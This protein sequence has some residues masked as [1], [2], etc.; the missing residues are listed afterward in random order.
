MIGKIITGKSFRNCLLYCLSDKH[1]NEAM[2]NR[3]EVLSYNQCYGNAKEL[4]KEFNDVRNLN[5]KVSKPVFHITLS[6]APGERLKNFELTEIAQQCAMDLDF[7]K[8]QFVAV[9][10]KDTLHQHLHIIAN[11]I[12]FDGRTVS[13]SNNY[14]KIVNFCRRVEAYYKLSTVLNPRRFLDKSMRNLPRS[15]QRKLKLKSDIADCL[16]KTKSFDEFT[17]EMKALGYSV[18]KGRG[19][20]FLDAQKVYTKGSDV[21]YS[22][23]K[24]QKVIDMPAEQKEAILNSVKSLRL[25]ENDP[26]KTI[27]DLSQKANELKTEEESI[28]L[29][30]IFSLKSE[31]IEQPDDTQLKKF[32]RKRKRHKL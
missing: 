3:A 6:L 29:P 18:I 5:T 19:I 27:S 30:E 26:A 12:G 32:K 31:K 21:G 16:T 13:D 14:W 1:V 22:L 2:V 10:H 9:L 4:A 7:E 28:R 17:S 25:Q 15:D 20:A 8:N 24:I 23:A 11:R